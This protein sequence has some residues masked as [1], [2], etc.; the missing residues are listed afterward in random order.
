[1]VYSDVGHD[2]LLQDHA[3]L[4]QWLLELVL[5][6]VFGHITVCRPARCLLHGSQFLHSLG[7]AQLPH[8][9]P[10]CMRVQHTGGS[11]L[12]A[13]TIYLQSISNSGVD[14]IRPAISH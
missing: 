12:P 6:K 14:D 8:V 11:T 7:A 5:L 9:A 4:P 3:N 1:M 13:R 10:M 2:S